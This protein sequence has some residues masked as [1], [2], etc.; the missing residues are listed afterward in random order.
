MLAVTPVRIYNTSSKTVKLQEK[1]KNMRL[2]IKTKIV[3]ELEFTSDTFSLKNFTGN[4]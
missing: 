3:T 1:L 4:F 2:L